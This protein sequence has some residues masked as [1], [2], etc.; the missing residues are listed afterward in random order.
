MIRVNLTL[1]NNATIEHR[2]QAGK[3]DLFV[4]ACCVVFC[5]LCCFLLTRCVQLCGRNVVD[6]SANVRSAASVRKLWLYDNVLRQVPRGVFDMAQLSVLVVRRN[7]NQQPKP[8]R[9]HFISST[10]IACEKSDQS[11]GACRS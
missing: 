5:G 7:R 2:I 3:E 6:V 4:R 1:I 11:S 8:T 10:R 9:H